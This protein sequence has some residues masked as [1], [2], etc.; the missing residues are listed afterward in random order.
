MQN[1]SK[2]TPSITFLCKVSKVIDISLHSWTVPTWL[3]KLPHLSQ[4]NYSARIAQEPTFTGALFITPH[5]S[6]IAPSFTQYCLCTLS[7]P[8]NFAQH[9]NLGH[10]DL[11]FGT[12]SSWQHSSLSFEMLRNALLRLPPRPCASAISS[13]HYA[14]VSERDA[15]TLKRIAERPPHPSWDACDEFIETPEKIAGGLWVT[16]RPRP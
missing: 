16:K 15:D 11:K 13:R 14:T 10:K 3:W 4:I 2:L 6:I 7:Y 8:I 9:K 12:C 1:S 5:H